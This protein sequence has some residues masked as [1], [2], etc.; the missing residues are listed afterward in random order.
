MNQDINGLT[1][2][3]NIRDWRKQSVFIIEVG[4]HGKT[5]R[6][7]I[8]AIAEDELT[9]RHII[10]ALERNLPASSRLYMEPYDALTGITTLETAAEHATLVYKLEIAAEAE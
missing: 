10:E 7:D 8:R 6:A 4:P 1:I 9:A 5:L 2:R 3:T